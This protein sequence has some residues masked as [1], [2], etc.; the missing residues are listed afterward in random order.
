M[1]HI[2]S[3]SRNLVELH[4]KQMVLNVRGF[5]WG[6]T[7]LEISGNKEVCFEWL[8]YYGC[9]GEVKKISIKNTMKNKNE[10]NPIR[11]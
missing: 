8:A 4:F 2:I 7:P 6:S 11:S 5:Q 9:F 1:Q 3:T 10:V